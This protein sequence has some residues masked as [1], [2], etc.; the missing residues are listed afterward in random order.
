MAWSLIRTIPQAHTT[1]TNIVNM[2]ALL[3]HPVTTKDE[4]EAISQDMKAV[5]P[6]DLFRMNMQWLEQMLQQ[7]S[8]DT[9]DKPPYLKKVFCNVARA[10]SLYDNTRCINCCNRFAHSLFAAN[11]TGHS[12]V[13]MER[14]DEGMRIE[15]MNFVT[16]MERYSGEVYYIIEQSLIHHAEEAEDAAE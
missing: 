3:G 5:L 2:E 4:I 8:N 10:T 9:K 12:F 7:F 16:F 11:S 6:E 13:V 1:Y 15:V 14:V